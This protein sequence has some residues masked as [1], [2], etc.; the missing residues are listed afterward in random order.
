MLGK[1]LRNVR[2][3]APL[4]HNITNYVTVNDVAN[5]LLACG[6]SPIMSDE[7]K[8]VE[9]ITSICGGL[10]VNI[11]TLTERSIEGMFLAGRRAKELGHPI[12]LD[13]AG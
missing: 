5:V 11:G 1:C 3:Q 2:A 6:A 10:N 7:P 9:D 12:L 13:P 8:D 4:V